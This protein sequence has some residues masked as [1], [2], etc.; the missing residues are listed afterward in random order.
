MS[1]FKLMANMASVCLLCLQ[2]QEHA[3]MRSVY[4][5]RGVKEANEEK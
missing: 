2:F 3:L 4:I 5:F 1:R